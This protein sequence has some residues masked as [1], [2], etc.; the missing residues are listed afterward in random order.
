[1]A[2]I[3]TGGLPSVPLHAPCLLSTRTPT[4]HTIK[5]R[6]PVIL[7]KVIDHLHRE[8]NNIGR[9]LGAEAMEGL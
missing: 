1:M 7:W 2:D 6:C 3:S 4:Y 8:R 9:E 5:D